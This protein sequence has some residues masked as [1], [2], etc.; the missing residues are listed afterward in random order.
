MDFKLFGSKEQEKLAEYPERIMRAQKF[1]GTIPSIED[2]N[3]VQ[4]DDVRNQ[5]RHYLR[6]LSAYEIAIRATA[7][8][9]EKIVTDANEDC[10]KLEKLVMNAPKEV[11]SGRKFS[12]TTSIVQTKQ[13]ILFVEQQCK[14]LKMQIETIKE[15]EA[16]LR[17][18]IAQ[19]NYANL[20]ELCRQL[21]HQDDEIRNAPR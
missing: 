20:A 19:N 9:Y 10:D 17:L 12:L 18:A 21:K 16:A 6:E 14:S 4:S 11:S 2:L 13:Q 5:I 8:Y 7:G 1:Q 3:L 15:T